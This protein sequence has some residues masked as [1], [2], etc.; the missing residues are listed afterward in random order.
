MH[1]FRKFNQVIIILSE[2]VHLKLE[3]SGM[4]A[5]IGIAA[6]LLCLG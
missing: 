4:L 2:S 1:V 6:M 5:I 3:S